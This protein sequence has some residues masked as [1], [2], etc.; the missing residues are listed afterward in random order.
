MLGLV[1][2]GSLMLGGCNGGPNL[3]GS[4]S[5]Y[6]SLTFNSQDII[7]N[8]QAIEITYYN[9]TP[10][11]IDV[12]ARLTVILSGID[13]G[14]SHTIDL[15]GEYAP[16]HPRAVVTHAVGGEP[17]R[18]L[19]PVSEGVLNLDS[20]GLPGQQ[21]NGSFDVT[22]GTGGDFGSGHTLNGSFSALAGSDPNIP[23][24]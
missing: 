13:L 17:P 24:E 7:R 4:L 14:K 19:P 2:L 3:Q 6:F 11:R 16:G 1:L 23:G 22:F 8:A 21:T 9:R 10:T 5:Q 12:V 18:T 15:S 20:G